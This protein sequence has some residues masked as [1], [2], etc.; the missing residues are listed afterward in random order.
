MCSRKNTRSPLRHCKQWWVNYTEIHNPFKEQ[1]PDS[2]RHYKK[3]QP[4]KILIT[5]VLLS[6]SLVAETITGKVISVADGDT[7]TILV[8]KTKHRIR[9][10]EI[11]APELKGQPYGKASKAHLSALVYN[12]LVL[13]EY[14][15]KDRYGRLIGTVTSQKVNVNEAMVIAGLAWHYK[16]Y[17]TQL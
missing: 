11:D 10:A 13:V 1:F 15:K 3:S 17:A 7:I 12:K 14:T 5:L 8:D 6:T 16:L 2:I 4:M 9:L